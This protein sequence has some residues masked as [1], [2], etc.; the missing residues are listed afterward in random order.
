MPT[1]NPKVSAYVPQKVFDQFKQFYEEHNLSMSHAVTRIFSEYFKIDPKVSNLR[2]YEAVLNRLTALEQKLSDNNGLLSE[3]DSE[4]LRR[5]NQLT[6]L[7]ASL[8]QRL[9]SLESAALQLEEL[10]EVE[11][12][13]A[14]EQTESTQQ[15]E[16]IS[17]TSEPTSKPLVEQ[18]KLIGNETINSTSEPLNE[19][20]KISEIELEDKP[21]IKVPFEA[22]AL[23]LGWGV[24]SL[25]TQ[26]SKQTEEDFF[27]WVAKKDR[28]KIYWCES[29]MDGRRKLYSPVSGTPSESLGKLRIW[30]EEN[31][32]LFT[33]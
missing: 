9:A 23:R 26:K 19:L 17:S 27:L 2:I 1:K 32:A 4:L 12:P 10:Q 20:P 15:L 6:D 31:K 33:L 18:L 5:L 25:R 8:E 24:K 21:E 13:K 30:V 28:D 7:V 29:A 11:I 16:L 3:P 14:I 22:I